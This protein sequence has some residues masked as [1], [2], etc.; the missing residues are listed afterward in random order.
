MRMDASPVDHKAKPNEALPKS[1]P[2]DMQLY[3]MIYLHE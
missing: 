1:L 3:I 2:D